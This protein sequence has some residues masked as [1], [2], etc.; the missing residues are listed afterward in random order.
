VHLAEHPGSVGQGHERQSRP[1]AKPRHQHRDH[2]RYQVGSRLRPAPPLQPQLDSHRC[3][4]AVHA[5]QYQPDHGGQYQ[6][7]HWL[8]FR[9]KDIPGVR[10][11]VSSGF[12]GSSVY[13]ALS[14]TVSRRL[15]YGLTVGA[16][17]TFSKA[18]G[19]TTYNPAVADN[20]EWNY[21]RVT[22]DRPH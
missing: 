14:A 10:P 3:G 9:A 21:G 11:D 8:Y 13:N 15:S 1:S 16:A 6:R 18:M 12:Q 20:H 22:G 7:R 19:V 17:Y 2:S 5:I 4:L